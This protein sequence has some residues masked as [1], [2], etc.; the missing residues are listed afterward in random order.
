MNFISIYK[1]SFVDV[2]AIAL[3]LLILLLS[4]FV[5]PKYLDQLFGFFEFILVLPSVLFSV[6]TVITVFVLLK[7]E[8]SDNSKPYLLE[9]LRVKSFTARPLF[10]S[11]VIWISAV[12]FQAIFIILFKD[13]VDFDSK[14]DISYKILNSKI[15]SRLTLYALAIGSVFIALAEELFW[16]GYLLPLQEKNWGKYS[17][18]INGALW[19]MT[20]IF[21]YNL[22]SMIF[23]FF[24]IPYIAYKYKNT[25]ITLIIHVLINS[26]S[27]INYINS[28]T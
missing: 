13:Y 6:F 3:I 26:L 17:W 24:A 7:K 14:L 19:G 4:S 11:L 1:K 22:W 8:G 18:I 5:V 21:V 23:V 2:F 25:S 12:I 16:R 28:Y 27:A 15:E 9:R 20:H 10:I